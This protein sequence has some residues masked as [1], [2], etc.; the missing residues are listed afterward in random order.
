[1]EL[2]PAPVQGAERTVRKIGVEEG[3]LDDRAAACSRF[4]ISLLLRT[5]EHDLL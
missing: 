2:L 4:F 3:P 5:G 1:M